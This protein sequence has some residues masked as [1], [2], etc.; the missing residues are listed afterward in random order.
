M[1]VRSRINAVRAMTIGA[2]VIGLL[3][4]VAVLVYVTA[5]GPTR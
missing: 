4:A 1:T 2:I 5:F 3:L